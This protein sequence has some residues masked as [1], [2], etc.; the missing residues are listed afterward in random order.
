MFWFDKIN[1]SSCLAPHEPLRWL[2]T[3]RHDGAWDTFTGRV[4]EDELSRKSGGTV[5]K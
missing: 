5:P 2:S 3:G 1:K 4:R